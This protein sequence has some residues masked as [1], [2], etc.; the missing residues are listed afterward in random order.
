MNKKKINSL[1]EHAEGNSYKVLE[2]RTIDL[3]DAL[4]DDTVTIRLPRE[5]KQL[6]KDRAANLR[7]PYQRYIKSVLIDALKKSS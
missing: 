1:R 4:A 3:R 2:D 6:L 7:M 5:L